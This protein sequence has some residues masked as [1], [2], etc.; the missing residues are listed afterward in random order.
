MKE[1]IIIM[2]FSALLFASSGIQS[3][4]AHEI[5]TTNP[6][7]QENQ[8]TVFVSDTAATNINSAQPLI[9][10]KV[11]D[12]DDSRSH[13]LS[14]LNLSNSK[15]EV[16][17]DTAE[18]ESAATPIE[19]DTESITFTDEE[20]AQQRQLFLQAE[21]ALQ[22]KDDSSYFLLSDQLK[23]YP[24]YPYLQYKWLRK[25]LDRERQVKHFL[26]Q[27][28]S[29]RY[30][31]KLKHKWL[32]YLGKH[33]QWSLLLENQVTTKNVTLSCYFHRAEFNSG[34]KSAALAG[35]QQLWAVGHSQP[36]V[37]DP[38][39]SQLRKS[40]LFT[41][42]LRWQRFD[43]ALKNNKVSLASYVKTLMPDKYHATAQL[44]LNL[45][46]DPARHMQ[47][48]LK[49]PRT[50][51]SA[52]MFRHA[53]DRLAAKD[54]KAAIKTWDANK[55]R[56]NINKQL[57]EKLERRLAL[58]LVFERETGAYER[59]GQLNEPS[60][61]SRA[62]RVRIALV[63]Q[64][65]PNVLTAIHAL[66]SKEKADEKW[67]YWL[68]RAYIETDKPEMAQALLI[69]LSSKRS[70]YG[71]LAADKVNSLYQLSEDPIKVSAE[72]I[73]ALKN[74]DEFR[75][76]FEFMVL[77]RKNDAKVQWWHATRQLDTKEIIVAAKLA[78]Q[79]QWDEIAI[80]TIAKAKHWDDIEL[81]FPL[82]YT[83]KILENSIQQKLNPAILFGLVRR[84]SA[85]NEKA[86]SPVGAR[87]LMQIMPGTARQIAKNLN[88]RW[89]G[90]NSLYNPE[91]N[92][93]YGSFYYQKLLNQFDGNYAI[94]LA[95]Y[96]AGPHR[97]KK[98]LPETESMPADIWIETIPYK[99]TREYV[100]NVLA[101]AL[102]YQ[103]R[104]NS[105]DRPIISSADDKLSMNDLTREVMPISAKP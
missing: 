81:R 44:W 90:N 48:M 64:N 45:H 82:S 105:N 15:A 10:A 46:R 83:D 68:A 7:T 76:A 62:W 84:E 98:W 43:A 5:K 54:I 53:I 101:Y 104:A 102:I 93:K 42:Y 57:A 19:T 56:F 63:E 30:A 21:S 18:I 37:C 40:A 33:K 32:H 59:L 69:E 60:S 58:K 80:F 1:N 50:S 36:A 85:F 87:G 74:T 96:N 91:T 100:I 12:I 13:N 88:E 47:K 67:Q 6:D 25:N 22:K 17:V 75:V 39:F 9:L 95:A 8:T 29:S 78:Q 66:N 3:Q 4:P 28:S 38:L 35:A 14:N 24:L 11:N 86:Y 23:D 72:E 16:I 71:F 94:A 65:W 27:Y 31:P 49:Q 41:Q 61:S 26:Q 20:I 51:E 70:F 2:S 99:E 55:Q 34:N 77:D 92:L 89:R 52:L 79:W 97:V 103:Q 73:T